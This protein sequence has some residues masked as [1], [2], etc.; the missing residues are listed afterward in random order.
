MGEVGEVGEDEVLTCCDSI[1][2]DRVA[3]H[4]RDSSG[5]TDDRLT[6][7]QRSLPPSAARFPRSLC[8]PTNSGVGESEYRGAHIGRIDDP[9]LAD[10]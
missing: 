4:Q 7:L 1:I 5:R 6:A 9:D 10:E 8:V 3:V 2:L